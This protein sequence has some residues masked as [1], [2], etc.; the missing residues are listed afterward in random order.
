MRKLFFFF[1]IF[2]LLSGEANCQLYPVT[3]NTI[4]YLADAPDGTD[5]TTQFKKIIADCNDGDVIVIPAGKFIVT[6]QIDILNKEIS[7][8]GN[9]ND[10]VS[11]TMLYRMPGVD[12][13]D[14][15]FMIRYYNWDGIPAGINDKIFVTG[16]YFK[17]LPSSRYS[18]GVKVTDLDNGLGFNK[19]PN[20]IVADNTFQYFGCSSISI[21]HKDS[22][23]GFNGLVFN[24][25][26]LDSYR[27]EIGNLGYGVAV[28]ATATKW[29]SD[30][31]FGSLRFPFIED[32]YFRETRHAVAA[33]DNAK[34]VFRYNKIIDDW[35]GGTIDAHGGGEWGYTFSTRAI[36]AYYNSIINSLDVINGEPITKTTPSNHYPV[37]AIAIR[38]GEAVIYN[39]TAVNYQRYATFLLEETTPG[40]YP[41]VYQIGYLSGLKYGANDNQH[42]GDHGNGDVFTWNPV[43]E[44]E[45]PTWKIYEIETPDTDYLK[46]NRDIHTNIVKPGYTAYQYP[47]DYRNYYYT[48]IDK[49][50]NNLSNVRLSNITQTSAQ[51]TWDNVLCEDGYYI[52]QSSDSINYEVVDTTNVND[53]AQI[54]SILSS[55]TKSWFYIRPFNDNKIGDK[56]KVISITTTQQVKTP[57]LDSKVVYV[58]PTNQTDPYQNGTLDHPYGSWGKVTWKEGYTYLQKKSTV[59]YE[60]KI[61]ISASH[62]VMNSYGEGEQP[63]IQSDVNDFAI[64]AF[65]KNDLIIKDLHIIAPEAVSCIYIIGET[66]DSISIENC[67]LENAVNGARI[68][69]GKNVILRYNT[70]VNCSDAVYCYAENS[71]IYYNVFRDNDIAINALGNMANAKIYNNVF[72]SNAVGIS[73][74][75][76][77]LTLYNNIFYL[78]NSN[79]VAINNQLNKLIS[80]NNIFYP[81]QDGFI[82]IANKKY[83][84]FDEYQQD[85]YVDLNSFTVDPKFV[86][87]Y[88]DNFS[89]EPYSPAINAGKVLGLQRDFFGTAV[90]LGG[91][92]DIGLAELNNPNGSPT[93]FISHLND[94]AQE[95]F[96]V[97]PNPSRGIFNVYVKNNNSRGSRITIKDLSGKTVYE[98]RFNDNNDFSQEIDISSLYKGIYLVVVEDNNRSL[99]QPIVIN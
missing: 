52:Y 44:Q 39:N 94:P 41:D 8:I 34:Y 78:V 27:P 54:I 28:A 96:Q 40:V 81:E 17:S 62:I 83:S 42:T 70:F 71:L 3:I 67:T 19:N 75:Y 43:F 68:L 16:I 23:E 32:N 89:L 50:L 10:S 25:S 49:F 5:I 20:F 1:F 88:N 46:F 18:G 80:D 26:F 60:S 12:I 14:Y 9:G 24:N 66:S 30:P 64:R 2:I 98:N 95:D 56:S 72:Y 38:G 87:I 53:T 59:S 65:E 97:F 84:S 13:A 90:P 29:I 15:S 76:A 82:Q 31:E 92:P 74:T 61:N 73:N 85:Y 36:E 79:D 99:S 37:T 51:L 47:H 4:R 6:G 45:F 91:L 93:S 7:I 35:M 69:N 55:S 33:G 77:E 21:A 22:I 86:D 63:V 58:D 48:F 57:L 11:G